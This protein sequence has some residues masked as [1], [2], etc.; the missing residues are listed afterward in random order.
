MGTCDGDLTYKINP[1]KFIED[2]SNNTVKI[3]FCKADVPNIKFVIK[4]VKMTKNS[5]KWLHYPH[6]APYNIRED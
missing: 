3:S 2:W 5:Q 6:L 4:D 1:I